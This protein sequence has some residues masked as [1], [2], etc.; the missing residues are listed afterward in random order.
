MG[1]SR[2]RIYRFNQL[3]GK[4]WDDRSEPQLAAGR[5][6]HADGE[7]YFSILKPIFHPSHPQSREPD[8]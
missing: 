3:F 4:K 7:F 2:G 5:E 1:K 8:V 6:T